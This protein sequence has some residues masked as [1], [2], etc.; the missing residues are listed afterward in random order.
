MTS[1]VPLSPIGEITAVGSLRRD[2][3]DVP[4]PS[5]LR[6]TVWTPTV[7]TLLGLLVLFST[8]RSS[9]TGGSEPTSIL[10]ARRGRGSTPDFDAVSQHHWNQIEQS[11]DRGIDYLVSVQ[12]GDGSYPGP[13]LERSA[14]TALAAM[15]MISRG[16][17]PGRGREGRSIERSIEFILN[18]QKPSGLLCNR[19]ED[20]S[21]P[22]I[23]PNGIMYSHGIC[24]MFLCEVY[25]MTTGRRSER[26]AATVSAALDY[27]RQRQTR[28]LP[29]GREALDRGGWRYLRP[30]QSGG[31]HSDLSVSS[32]M[33][34]FMRSAENAGFDVPFDWAK[35]SLDFVNRCYDPAT[36]A[37]RYVPDDPTHLTRGMTAAGV[38]CLFLT[39]NEDPAME[40]GAANYLRRYPF[41]RFNEG[42][43]KDDRYFYSAY[44]VSQAS[45]QLGGPTW[46]QLYPSIARALIQNQRR[47]GSWPVERR[48]PWVGTPYATAMAILAMTPP[49]QLLPIYQR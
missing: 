36:G 32:W 33:V 39:G 17:V 44:Y 47:D 37:F 9:T 1:L 25:G 42:M 7:R 3:D 34:M 48:N 4:V 40:S 24:G 11:V 38:L 18:I 49:Y 46:L 27:M 5:P 8:V 10:H 41:D 20:F 19:V 21:S 26:I 45:M 2:R 31:Y 15:A 30:D 12:K 22:G 13:M 43:S 35:L 23:G 14:I 29:A 16:H 6:A 28:P